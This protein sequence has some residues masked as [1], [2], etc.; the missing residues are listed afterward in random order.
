MPLRGTGHRTNNKT[1]KT[2]GFFFAF[3][4]GKFVLAVNIV[5]DN[6]TY[7]WESID[8]SKSES[9]T[10]ESPHRSADARMNGQYL[11]E[12]WPNA[13]SSEVGGMYGDAT[14]LSDYSS[15]PSAWK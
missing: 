13:T 3:Q 12:I 6:A 11:Y 8:Y 7:R 5:G 1:D 14:K 15:I 4:S 9:A 10:T 2:V